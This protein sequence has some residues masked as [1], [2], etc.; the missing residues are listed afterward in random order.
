MPAGEA[1]GE[2]KLPETGRLLKKIAGQEKKNSLSIIMKKKK[3]IIMKKRHSIIMEHYLSII[4][5]KDYYN[6]K[7]TLMKME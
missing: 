6:I 1:A 4:K 3:S 7:E 5:K 2:I